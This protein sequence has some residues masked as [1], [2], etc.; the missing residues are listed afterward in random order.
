[1]EW[2]HPAVDTR[3]EPPAPWCQ[4]QKFFRPPFLACRIERSMCAPSGS[5]R[6]RPSHVDGDYPLFLPCAGADGN[7]IAGIRQGLLAASRPTHTGWN[8]ITGATGTQDLCT[9]IGGTLPFALTH[10]EQPGSR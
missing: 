5:S 10:A 4:P 7:A 2:N 9:Q 3:R 1:M 8:R 6:Q